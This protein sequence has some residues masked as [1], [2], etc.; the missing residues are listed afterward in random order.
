MNSDPLPQ[1]FVKELNRK[2][3]KNYSKSQIA[4]W[5]FGS[6]IYLNQYILYMIGN[7][8]KKRK[9]IRLQIIACNNEPLV[10]QHKIR[11]NGVESIVD[12]LTSF[13]LSLGFEDRM[14]FDRSTFLLDIGRE[15]AIRLST[16]R[17]YITLPLM[18]G[19]GYA[20]IK[21]YANMP[22]FEVTG[23][24]EGEIVTSMADKLCA[25]I[26][27]I[28]KLATGITP[29]RV[30]Q[31]MIKTIYGP[32]PEGMI[33]ETVDYPQYEVSQNIDIL[34]WEGAASGTTM[35]TTMVENDIEM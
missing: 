34:C 30:L 8:N 17:K 2:Q 28:G 13:K 31:T 10:G 12:S 24:N 3:I 11:Y 25:H 6:V 26:Y 7:K 19:P 18:R 33:E 16:L 9:L 27:L 21:L 23:E 4:E 32:M 35:Q 14:G 1:F 22:S 20:H 5:L 29:D 15:K